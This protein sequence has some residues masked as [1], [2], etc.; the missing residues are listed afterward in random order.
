MATL[1]STLKLVSATRATHVSPVMQR[2]LA[3]GGQTHQKIYKFIF[4]IAPSLSHQRP[5]AGR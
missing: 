5:K 1:L 3:L 4:H 2:S